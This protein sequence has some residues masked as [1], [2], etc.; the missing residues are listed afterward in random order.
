MSIR[1]KLEQLKD[2]LYEPYA[3]SDGETTVKVQKNWKQE[4]YFGPDKNP[5]Y[6]II[7]TVRLGDTIKK[8]RLLKG[9]DV[10]ICPVNKGRYREPTNEELK[11][12]ELRI[13]ELWDAVYAV[14]RKT[15][16]L[17]SRTRCYLFVHKYGY[18]KEGRVVDQTRDGGGMRSVT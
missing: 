1:E 16:E 11:E 8:A 13:G 10:E 9:C 4:K 17:T 7:F 2:E 6:R 5:N 18:E 15:T 3:F 12:V 14:N